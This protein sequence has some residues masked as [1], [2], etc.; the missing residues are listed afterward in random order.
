M[1]IHPITVF[2]GVKSHFYLIDE[3]SPQSNINETDAYALKKINVNQIASMI[4]MPLVESSKG[5]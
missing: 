1:L 2:V 5:F 4:E 3:L